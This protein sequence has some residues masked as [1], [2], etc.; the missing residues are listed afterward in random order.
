[1]GNGTNRVYYGKGDQTLRI[2]PHRD[3]RP[4]RVTAGTYGI[5]DAR[6]GAA[7][8]VLVAAGTAASVDAVSTTLSAKAGRYSN[9]HRVLVVT[10]TAGIVA[11]REYLLESSKGLAEL[12]RIVSIPDATHALASGDIRGDFPAASTLRGVEVSATFPGSAADDDTNLDGLPWIVVWAFAGFPPFRES[13]FLER[14]EESQLATLD[15]LRELD[16]HLS[17]VGGDRIEPALALARA[18]K[19][20]RTDI[21]LAGAPE[22]DFLSGPIGRDAVTYRAAELMLQHSEDPSAQRRYEYYGKRY[23]EL[24]AAM[25]VGS[26]KPGIVTLD[27]GDESAETV[28]PANLFRMFGY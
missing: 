16:P 11:G 25:Q 3:G 14:G 7:V 26:K 10:S 6:P 23:Q 9:D 13:I 17:N 27:K 1:M 28:N 8:P 22:A 2:I 5:F 18:Q 12:V 20:W 19:D 24:R 15:D 21:M 4:V